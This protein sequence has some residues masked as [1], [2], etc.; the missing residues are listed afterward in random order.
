VKLAPQGVAAFLREPGACRVVLLYGDDTG[1]IRDRADALTRAVAGSLDDPFLIAELEHEDI[2]QLANEAASL[3]LGGGRRVVRLRGIGNS[4][5]DEHAVEHVLKGPG[6]ALVVLEGPGLPARSRLRTLLESASDGAAIGCYPEERAALQ[7]TIRETLRA[8][9]VEITADA[10]TWLGTRLGADRAATRA[11]IEKLALYAG[12]G[13]RVDLDAAMVCVGDLAG[14]SLDDAWFAVTEGDV[15]TADRALELAV[16]EGATP[17]GVLRTGLGHLQRLYRARL[18]V[19]SG[20]RP[21]DAT[22]A[23]RPPVFFRRSPAFIRAIGV[24]SSTALRQAIAR[25]SQAE[26]NC[27]QTGAPDTS[28][29]RNVILGLARQAAPDRAARR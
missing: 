18:L 1:M 5:T 15:A 29:A 12:A 9:G 6:P 2:G 26:R 10:L 14:L 7:Q 24:W 23:L 11:E 21:Q 17:V 22:S 8:A 4:A 19:D 16:A 28:I 13:A 20:M 25:T 27:K 3:P